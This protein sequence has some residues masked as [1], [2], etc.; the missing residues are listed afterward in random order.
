[1]KLILKWLALVLVLVIAGLALTAS[2]YLRWDELPPPEM[3][4]VVEGGVLD[5][6]GLQRSWLAY[7]PASVGSLIVRLPKN[8]KLMSSLNKLKMWRIM[9]RLPLLLVRNL[10][11]DRLL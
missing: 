5:H 11:N 1:M 7:V 8:N 6:D 4:G 10:I 2:W 3:P 9:N